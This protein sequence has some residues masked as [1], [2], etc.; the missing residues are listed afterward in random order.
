MDTISCLNNHIPMRDSHTS[1]Q[2]WLKIYNYHVRNIY[3]MFRE[4]LPDIKDTQ[5]NYIKI[6]NM[7][8]NMSSRVI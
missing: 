5:S 4:E 2:D 8:Y 7:I 3:M 6:A 1:F